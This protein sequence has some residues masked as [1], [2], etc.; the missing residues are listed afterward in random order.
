MVE[1]TEGGNLISAG[2][3]SEMLGAVAPGS[4][5]DDDAASVGPEPSIA[6]DTSSIAGAL[7]DLG[8]FDLGFE[9]GLPNSM[10]ADA[11]KTFEIL[12]APVV[13]ELSVDGL[14]IGVEYDQMKP[15][16]SVDQMEL[17]SARAAGLRR[18]FLKECVPLW[19]WISICGR[20]PEMEDAFKAAPRFYDIPLWMLIGDCAMDGLSPSKISLPSHFFGV[21]DG[22]G[23][24]QVANYCQERI[25]LAL[26]DKLARSKEGLEGIDWQ[27]QWERAFSDCFTKIDDEVGGKVSR[28]CLE[29]SSEG[30]GGR[31]SLGFSTTSDPVAPETVGSTAVV[32]IICSSHII[33]A[34]CGDSRAVLCRG[35]Q[36]MPLSVD[37]KPNREDE[38]A[39]IEAAGGK[40]I[41]WNGY[42]VFGVLAM[43]RSI[44]DRYLKPWIIPEP[45]VRIISRTKEDEC[46]ILA[47]DGLW[48][49]MSN[50]EACDAARRRLLLWHKKNAVSDPSQRGFGPDP[51]AQSAAD[52]LSK[53]ALQKGS[54]DNITV[55]VIDLKSH[56]KFKP[57]I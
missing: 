55:I 54:K 5:E 30:G 49:V 48:D 24:V 46:L 23:G 41:Q 19:G 10:D 7:D 22:H 29:S 32:S 47:S 35:K 12:A 26:A 8:N 13:E 18:L 14:G 21:Y 27:K 45:E 2:P 17:Q 56:R 6:S 33:V 43:S 1:E 37:H 25:H 42:R 57:K 39:R 50:E 3:D 16:T 15:L 40:V 20:R 36:A 11:A 28:V 52:Y 4:D 44:G 31:G 34:N 9:F 53:L 38:Y 51:A